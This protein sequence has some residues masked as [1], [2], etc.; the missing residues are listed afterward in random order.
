M[1]AAGIDVAVLSHTIG[2]VEG[3]S[4]PTVAVSTAR[5]VNDFLA[6][7]I[8]ASGGR[9]A[10]FAG[11]ALQDVDAAVKELTRVIT[12]LEVGLEHVW[13]EHAGRH[14]SSTVVLITVHYFR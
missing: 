7:E 2:S 5:R 12:D 8:A 13:H 9:F 14:S 4:D 1:D 11:V 10:G 6:A 3:I